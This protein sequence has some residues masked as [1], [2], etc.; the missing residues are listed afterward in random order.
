MS[1]EKKVRFGK[2]D[3]LPKTRDAVEYQFRF[4][5]ADSSL[6]GAPEKE[7]ETKQHIVKVGI[8]GVLDACWGLSRPDLVK[9]LFEYGKRH[10]AEKLKG[11]TLSDKEELQ[12]SGSSYP[13]KCPFDP[14]MISD[15]SQASINVT[16]PGKSLDA[17]ST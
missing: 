4:T 10:I 7:S 12:L 3:P 1:Y 11:G 5:V 9:V 2:P 6:V 8:S 15:P 16:I 14:S 13:D 17:E